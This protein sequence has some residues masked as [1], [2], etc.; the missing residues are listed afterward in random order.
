M[1]NRPHMLMMD[2]L[3]NQLTVEKINHYQKTNIDIK[4]R[5][6]VC[7]WIDEVIPEDKRTMQLRF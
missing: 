7:F 1:K 4:G 6:T 2:Y 5:A 3:L